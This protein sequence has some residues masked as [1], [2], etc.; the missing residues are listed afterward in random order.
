MFLGFFFIFIILEKWVG[1]VFGNEIIFMGFVSL[2]GKCKILFFF[3]YILFFV[4]V[5]LF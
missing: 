5:K 4:V 3:F 1:W 2:F